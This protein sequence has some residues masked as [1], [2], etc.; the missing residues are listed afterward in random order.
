MFILTIIFILLI[1][2]IFGAQYN[3]LLQKKNQVSNAFSTVDVILQ[4]RND[5]IP[6]L[7]T[8]AQM[9][10][11]FEQKTLIE[12]SRLRSRATLKNLS[13]NSRVALEDQI[14]R[15]LSKIILVLEAYPKLKTN[16][17]L[18]NCNILSLSEV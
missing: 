10:M 2:I 17:I 5:L 11:Q 6:R 7:V 12:T 13:D 8:L 14:S 15:M 16:S 4:K 9:Y 1:L 3:S 18:S